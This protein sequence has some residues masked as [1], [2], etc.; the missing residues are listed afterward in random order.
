MNQERDIWADRGMLRFS[1]SGIPAAAESAD[2][3][4]FY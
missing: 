4:E 3:M 2:I 1:S